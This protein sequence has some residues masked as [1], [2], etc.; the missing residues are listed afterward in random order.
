MTQALEALSLANEVRLSRAS[1]KREIRA[2]PRT[3]GIRKV[4][5]LV[6]A[7]PPLWRTARLEQ[8]LAAP[9]RVGP[10]TVHQWLRAAELPPR[11]QVGSLT[12]R[13]RFVLAGLMRGIS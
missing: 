3:E 5:D 7:N 10:S 13:Q 6:E 4:A 2:M 8:L 1:V 12:E 9:F 11:K